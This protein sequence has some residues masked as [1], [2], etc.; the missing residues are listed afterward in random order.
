MSGICPLLLMA[1]R[2]KGEI[3][4]AAGKNAVECLGE[5]CAWFVIHE[6][7]HAEGCAMARIADVLKSISLN[8]PR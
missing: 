1:S 4:T 3:A 8:L 2:H 6:S 7:P 5:A